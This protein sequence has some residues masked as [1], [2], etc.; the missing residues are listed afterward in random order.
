MFTSKNQMIYCFKRFSALCTLFFLALAL[1]TV[2]ICA[3]NDE[4]PLLIGKYQ[5]GLGN[6][7]IY[8][9]SASGANYWET[10][11]TKGANNWMYPGSGMSNPIY[12]KFVSSSYGSNMDFFAKKKTYWD[13]TVRNGI[14]AETQ[15]FDGSDNRIYG[16]VKDWYYARIYIND[17]NFRQSSFTNEQAQGTI[18]HEMGHAFGF[19]ENYSNQNS[20]MCQLGTEEKFKEFKW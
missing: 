16:A 7:T 3:S 1:G 20:I 17:D 2:N 18:I 4:P 6:V 14:L 8:I 19:N 12:I 11:I 10:Y 9:D 13:A 5:N 15:H